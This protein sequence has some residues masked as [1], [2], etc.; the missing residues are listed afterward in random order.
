MALAYDLLRAWGPA[1]PFL[2]WEVVPDQVLRAWGSPA[3]VGWLAPSAYHGRRWLTVIGEPAGAAELAATALATADG[4]GCAGVSLPPGAPELVDGLALR[5]REAWTWWWTRQPP[6]GPV[7][8]QVCEIPADDPRL[9]PLLAQSGSVYLQPGDPRARA[10]YGYVIGERLLGCLALEQHKAGV[11]HMASVVVDAAARRSGIGAAL[12]GGVA[13]LALASGAPAVTLGMMTTNS[14]AAAL[15]RGVGFRPGP[16][17]VSG[18][19][20]GRTVDAEPGWVHG[21]GAA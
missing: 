20:A 15:Y 11:P 6:P 21:G 8:P 3:A 5:H 1:E 16:S 10:W 2:A 4:Q 13:A 12:C 14:A 7:A 9:P 17:F 18:T 19:I